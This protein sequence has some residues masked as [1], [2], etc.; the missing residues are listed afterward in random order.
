M[1]KN[2][3]EKGRNFRN[4]NEKKIDA[5]SCNFG[6]KILRIADRQKKI[7]KKNEKEM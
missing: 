3:H 5:C 4:N 2:E 6:D 1:S 7:L